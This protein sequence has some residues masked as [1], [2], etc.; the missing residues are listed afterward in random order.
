VRPEDAPPPRP[1]RLPRR[2]PA[3]GRFRLLI[4]GVVVI[5]FL[6]LVSVRGL[7]GFYTDYLWFDSLG[8]S[9]VFRAVFGA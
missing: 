1:T 7:A 9:S 4:L 6:A 5:G 2:R 8:H 3:F